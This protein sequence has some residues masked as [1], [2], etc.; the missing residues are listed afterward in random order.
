MGF[1]GSGVS[2]LDLGGVSGF[3]IFGLG[4]GLGLAMGCKTP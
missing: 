3:G 4:F 1:G 2:G